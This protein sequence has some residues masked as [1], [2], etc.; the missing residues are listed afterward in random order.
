MTSLIVFE[1]LPF[2]KTSQKPTPCKDAYGRKKKVH[3]M[4][5]RS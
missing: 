1:Q 2:D 3:L 5:E 4:V